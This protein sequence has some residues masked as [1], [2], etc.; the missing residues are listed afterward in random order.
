MMTSAASHG[1][2]H[3]VDSIIWIH[4]KYSFEVVYE[5]I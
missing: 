3:G 2:Q 5:S 1:N 4:L